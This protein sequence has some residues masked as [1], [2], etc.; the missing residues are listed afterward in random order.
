MPRA[1]KPAAYPEWLFKHKEAWPR[2]TDGK[3]CLWICSGCGGPN[4]WPQRGGKH[5]GPQ[6]RIID[7]PEWSPAVGPCWR[8]RSYGVKC[9]TPAAVRMLVHEGKDKP[10]A[11]LMEALTKHVRRRRRE[12]KAKQEDE[13]NAGI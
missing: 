9:V 3:H 4:W 1:K 7:H 10:P 6:L 8:S 5:G 13:N 11:D 12:L 2:P